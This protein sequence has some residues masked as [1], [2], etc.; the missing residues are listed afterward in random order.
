MKRGEV[1]TVAGSSDYAGKPRLVVIVQDDRFGDTD[2]VTVCLL[3][4][5]ESYAPFMRIQIE[6]KESN[7]LRRPSRLMT[8]KLATVSKS[9]LG[10]R[11]GR[12]SS[13]ELGT[14]NQS[15]LL[16]LGL[17]GPSNDDGEGVQ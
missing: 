5:V 10:K 3:T 9:K 17:L 6:P 8:D 13:A 12:L 4:T 1:W 11:I 16:F 7:G 2:S 14:M 15:I